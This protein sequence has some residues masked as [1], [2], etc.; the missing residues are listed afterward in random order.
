[1]FKESNMI[2]LKKEYT[3]SY[4]KTVCA[5]ANE[6]DG[7][8]IFG[9][10][11]DGEVKGIA[12]DIELKQR[13]ENAINDSIKPVPTYTLETQEMFEKK[14]VVVNVC[15]GYAIPYLYKGKPYMRTDTATI[16]AD[17]YRMRKWFQELSNIDFDEEL[18]NEK[19]LVFH[20]LGEK[21][22]EQLSLA[23]IDEGVLVS[24]GLKKQGQYT[25]AGRLFADENS[26]NFGVDIVKFGKDSSEFIKRLRIS[27]QSLLMQYDKAIEFFD[28]Y[29]HHYEVIHN[30]VREQRVRIPRNA[31][32]EALANAIVHRD[33]RMK[34]NIQIEFW[35]DY[36]K[37]TSP[38]GLTSDISVEQYLSGGFSIPRNETIANIFY[39]LDLIETFGTG[40]V[41]IKK[42]YQTFGQEP[43]FK[44]SNNTIE[45]IL[46]VI[47]Y[48]K[49]EKI[50]NVEEKIVNLVREGK[51]TRNQLEEELSLSATSVKKHLSAMVANGKIERVGK[52][53][54]TSYRLM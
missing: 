1:M 13:I 14:I 30:G 3:K 44:V 12:D 40:I 19:N 36:I 32:R 20:Y 29:Y 11:D 2:E 48:D 6:R 45:V 8:I 37:I 10:D 51:N 15:R 7:K 39:R 27:N 28:L 47:D 24:L 43:Q 42:L 49:K 22:R 33:Y 23:N 50:D 52:G 18:A 17:E 46:P 25:N 26:F 41:R 4:L 5:F 34:A 54:Y 35:D 16:Q 9:V 21:F 53:R 38:G 31:F